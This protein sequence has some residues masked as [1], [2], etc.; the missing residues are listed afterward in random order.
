MFFDSRVWPENYSRPQNW[1]LG[2]LT[3]INETENYSS[4]RNMSASFEPSRVKIRRHDWPVGEL[5]EKGI[6]K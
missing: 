3:T 2:V 4:L 5:T 1:G 6:N